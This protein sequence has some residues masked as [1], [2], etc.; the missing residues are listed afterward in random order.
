MI[1]MLKYVFFIEGRWEARAGWTLLYLTGLALFTLHFTLTEEQIQ[2]SG[3]NFN[4]KIIYEQYTRNKIISEIRR[5]FSAILHRILF[6]LRYREWYR[7]MSRA[8][9]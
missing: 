3:V 8:I 5:R 9:N 4:V 7:K 6:C 1:L 2:C